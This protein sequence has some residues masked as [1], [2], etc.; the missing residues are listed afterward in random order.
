MNISQPLSGG[1][2]E[3]R[4]GDFDSLACCVDNMNLWLI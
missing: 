3:D 1:F 2:S 4:N